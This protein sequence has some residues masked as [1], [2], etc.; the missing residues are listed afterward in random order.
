MIPMNI[1]RGTGQPA[2]YILTGSWGK[3]ALK[4]GKREGE[5]HVAWDGKESNY[6]HVPHEF[7]TETQP[8]GRD[9]PHDVERDD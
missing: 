9:G 1:V 2:D 4:E 3:N 6:D 8:A 5:V 7:R